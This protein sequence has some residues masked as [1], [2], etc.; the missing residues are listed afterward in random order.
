MQA[1]QKQ[2]A[3]KQGATS[4]IHSAIGDTL[5]K[6]AIQLTCTMFEL[7]DKA[8]IIVAVTRIKL[9]K[10]I[11]F[12]GDKNETIDSIIKLV[13]TQSQWTDFMENILSLVTINDYNINEILSLNLTNFPFRVCNTSLP[14]D[15]SGYVY[16]LISTQTQ[17]Y[18]YIGE[19]NNIIS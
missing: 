3:L 7:W 13:Q 4:T 10:N 1:Q 6:V 2:Y 5:N 18:I 16:F 8:Q 15:S 19:C 14:Q 9:G 11:I 12:V 17:D